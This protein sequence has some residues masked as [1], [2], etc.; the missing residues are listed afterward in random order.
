ML[1]LNTIGCHGASGLRRLTPTR[2]YSDAKP[3]DRTTVLSGIQPTGM[4]HIGNYLGAIRNWLRLQNGG[5]ELKPDQN[6]F[7]IA[8]LHAITLP[9]NRAQLNKN[10]HEMATYLLACGIDPKKSIIYQ[11]SAVPQHSELA[12]ILSCLSQISLLERMT[13]WKSKS[14]QAAERSPDSASTIDLYLGL[15]A[16]PVLQAADILL[17][18]ATHIPVGHDQLQHLELARDLSEAFHRAFKTK[19]LFP[20]PRALM[21]ETP[22]VMSLIQPEKKMSKSDA[23]NLSW[24]GLLDPPATVA[25][26]IRKAKTDSEL[27]AA[28]NR[29]GI[30]F[31]PETR[32]GLSNLLT[33]YAAIKGQSPEAATAD[34]VACSDTPLGIPGLKAILIEEVIGFL[35]PIQENYTRLKNEPGYV[36]GVLQDG[37][38]KAS[39]MAEDTMYKVRA[40]VGIAQ[41]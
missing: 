9:Q 20:R 39:K 29:I 35:A 32:P 31:D 16:Y 25:K 22:R 38:K 14:K 24:I 28:G 34:L 30:S 33:I 12:W 3:A 8:D 37:A 15:F 27:D 19:S 1:L 18:R 41:H 26:K 7:M 36:Q 40:A 11:Q 13:Q 21:T 4:L 23:S 6:L 10:V 2:A 5:A 17:Y